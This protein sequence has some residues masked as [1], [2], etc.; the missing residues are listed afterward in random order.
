MQIEIDKLKR[1]LKIRNYSPRTIKSYIYALEQYFS[2][3][4][5]DFSEF[6]DNNVKEFLLFSENRGLSAQSRNLLLNAI[7]YYY[8]NIV[9]NYE[10]V[11][12]RSAK[13]ISRL[14]VILSKEEIGILLSGVKNIKHKLLLSIT[15]GAG[16]RVSEVISLKV[17]D[18]DLN[19][20]TI[21]VKQAK[22]RR[23]RIS[24]LPESLVK[25]LIVFI[26][27]KK[28]GG[29][30]FESQR[31]GKLSART[32]QKIFENALEKS[33][34]KKKPTFH[35]LRHSFATHLLENGVNI[36]YIQELLGHQ[37]IRTTQIYTH[38]TNP[39]LK[40]IRSPL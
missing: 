37:N 22:G 13:K 7:K 21:H 15:Y 19:C 34:I 35:S 6:D 24:I 1:E 29:Y 2:F 26:N 17:Q 9:G 27:A 38:L 36:R 32:A 5:K 28:A 31:G 30:L 33:R 25:S 18:I 14:P 23:D 3:K 10:L 8:R 11:G 39:Q 20:L 16:L 12:I 4:K 40:N